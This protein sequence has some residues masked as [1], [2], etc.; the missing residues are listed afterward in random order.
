MEWGGRG[1]ISDSLP[2]QTVGVINRNGKT[3]QSQRLFSNAVIGLFL[4]LLLA[5]PTIWLSDGVDQITM[6]CASVNDSD[7][8]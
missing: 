6:R 4:S 2:Y 8:E 1:I 3:N 5:T 7:S